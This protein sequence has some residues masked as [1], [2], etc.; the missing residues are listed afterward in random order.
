MSVRVRFR[1]R[2]VRNGGLCESN[3]ESR[4]LADVRVT[5]TVRVTVKV[6]VRRARAR[7]RVRV[8]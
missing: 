6:R 2:F 5:V 7:V 1:Y 4:I 3:P 8:R